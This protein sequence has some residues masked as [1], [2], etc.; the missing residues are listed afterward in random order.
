MSSRGRIGITTTAFAP[1]NA[2]YYQLM[3]DS[4][5]EV[6]PNATGRKLSPDET[7]EL[8]AGAVGVV[9]GTNQFDEYVLR[10]LPAL[11][12]ISRCGVGLDSVDLD[13]AH[14]LDIQVLTTPGPVTSAVAELTIGLMLAVLRR[15]AEADRLI[16]RGE[17]SQLT[18]GLLSARTVGIIGFGRIGQRVASLAA[19]FGSNVVA[20]DPVA[21]SEPTV[22]MVSLDELLARA[23]VISLHVPL[24]AGTAGLIGERE[25]ASVKPTAILVNSCRG[26]VIDEVALDV[27]LERGLLAG[28]GLDTFATEPYAGPLVRHPNVVFTAHMGAAAAESREQMERDAVANLLTALE[29]AAP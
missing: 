26:G 7:V 6:V 15:V 11:R 27:A 29:G 12:V 16:R 24:T 25:L 13:V 8:L 1:P 4:G 2:D 18:G 21:P 5:Y 17:W 10:R 9:A 28:A 3:V 23:D 19:A 20:Y 22:A 14:E